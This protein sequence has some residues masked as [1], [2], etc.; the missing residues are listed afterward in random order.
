M[1]NN[2]GFSS[3]LKITDLND[4]ITPSQVLYTQISKL[5]L[6][7]KNCAK[8]SFMTIILTTPYFPFKGIQIEIK[9]SFICKRLANVKL[10]INE[11]KTAMTNALLIHL[12]N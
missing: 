6:K 7:V 10:L 5:L 4:F 11:I 8:T 1:S 2:S 12:I 3:A 9:Y